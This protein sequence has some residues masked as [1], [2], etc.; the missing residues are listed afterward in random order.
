MSK[1]KRESEDYWLGVRDALRMVD[2]FVNWS[3]RNPSRA[4]TI[5]DFITDGLLAAAKR[6]ESCLSHELGLSF[7]GESKDSEYTEESTTPPSDEVAIE[8]EEPTHESELQFEDSPLS[9]AMGYSSTDDE[10]EIV[11]PPETIELEELPV[12]EPSTGDPVLEIEEAEDFDIPSEPL[13]PDEEN[14]ATLDEIESTS[15]I[16]MDELELESTPRDFSSDFDVAEPEPYVVDPPRSS[17][18]EPVDAPSAETEPPAPPED[19]TVPPPP[20]E[21]EGFTWREY[22][23]SVTPVEE[24][25]TEQDESVSEPI[26]PPSTTE[27]PVRWSPYDEP[28]L[29]ADD[30]EESIEPEEEEVE[31]EDSH[32][33]TSEPKPPPPPPPESDETEEERRRRARRLFFGT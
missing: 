19:A 3:R 17:F 13:L 20:S 8:F 18:D 32:E 2:S 31:I 33:D 16:E 29:P 25:T 21:D 12:V 22:E 14:G 15:G 10:V 6:C 11:T 28:S 4:K 5:N 27:T 1:D 23:T 26:S 9:D 7:T 30:S 24:S